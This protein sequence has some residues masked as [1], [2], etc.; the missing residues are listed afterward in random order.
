MCN[1]KLNMCAS[2][3]VFAFHRMFVSGMTLGA[4][5]NKLKI[6]TGKENGKRGT[7]FL[8]YGI[9][10][11]NIVCMLCGCTRR[12][13]LVLEAAGQA[14]EISTSKEETDDSGLTAPEGPQEEGGRQE[15][16]EQAGSV[17]VEEKTDEQSS[18]G[19]IATGQMQEQAGENT[20]IC[21]HVCGAV[22]N[23]G[24]YELPA[25]SR[26]YEAVKAAGGFSEEA[27]ESYVNQAQQLA[28]GSKLV[29][30]TVDQVRSA[31]E[32]GGTGTE[33]IGIVEQAALLGGGETV[34]IE[35]GSSTEADGKVN[36]NTASEAQLCEIPGIGATRAA[37]ITTYRQ[38]HGSF[39]S[40]EEI[41]NVSGIKEGTYTKIK[42]CI[43]VN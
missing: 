43:K 4:C 28:D 34:S 15:N 29:I 17:S 8:V 40:I 3:L 18:A 19:D 39:H 20:M 5:I 12:E 27:D 6:S 26:V 37:A 42:D 33:Q 32:D 1:N 2:R 30:P 36:I 14:Q 21:V 16:Q 25:G 22:E 11:C 13:Q 38:E 9:V 41:M 7:R 23:A 35:A 31:P 24:V 10:V